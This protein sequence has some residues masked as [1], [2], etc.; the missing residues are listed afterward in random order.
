LTDKKL[1]IV[2]GDIRNKKNIKKAMKDVDVVYHL[3]AK[4]DFEGKKYREYKNVNVLGTKNLVDACKKGGIKKF[5]F[6][7]SVGVYGFPAVVGDIKGWNETHP[8]T[9]TNYY[10]RSKVEAEEIIVNAH[11]KWG[12]PYC[13]IRPTTVYGPREKGPILSLFKA[14][15]SKVFFFIGDGDFKLHY[16][17]VDDLIKAAR[18]AE[19]SKLN[20][21]DYIIAGPMPEKFKDIVRYMAK[22]IGLSTPK[23]K[24]PGLIIMPIAYVLGVIGKIIRIKPPLYPRRVRTLTRNCYFDISKAKHELGWIPRTTFK[25]DAKLT[26]RWYLKNNFL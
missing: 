13:I 23:L 11:Q 25:K 8:K 21:G 15:K 1:D 7:S 20:A 5:V 24:I 26:A 6:F 16:V 3:A 14:I 2:F 19:K 12:L 9:F 17:F 4:T 22:S 10:G 18:L